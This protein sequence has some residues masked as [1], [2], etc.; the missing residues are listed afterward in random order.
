MSWYRWLSCT[1]LVAIVDGAWL[2]LLLGLFGFI[3]GIGHAQ[4][5]WLVATAVLVMGVLSCAL[6]ELV[7]QDWRV[8]AALTPC[9]GLLVS[10]LA[11][12]SASD[13]HAGTLGL[14]WPIE[15]LSGVV[16][17]STLATVALAAGTVA[18]LWWHGG[19]RALG[20]VGT[21]AI[22]RSFRT[23]L[24]VFLVLLA[25]EAA[26]D[27][28][29]GTHIAMGPFFI[30]SL[31]GMALARAPA[32]GVTLLAW[33][34]LIGAAIVAMVLSGLV[35]AL[36]AVAV[37]RG[38]FS[39]LSDVWLDFAQAVDR[40]VSATLVELLGTREV[41][42]L[43][44]QTTAWD[45]PQAFIL[46]VVVLGAMLFAPLFYRLLNAPPSLRL[47]GI[48]LDLGRA[49]HESIVDPG[50]D[51]AT[52][53]LETLLPRWRWRRRHGKVARVFPEHPRLAQTF[54][55]YYQ[56]LER[57]RAMGVEINLA[58]TPRER[59]A[60]LRAAFPEL[61]VD[62]LTAVFEAACY[63]L[64]AAPQTELD[65]LSEQCDGG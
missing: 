13:F 17:L 61:P 9:L 15:L 64:E 35:L 22:A 44:L 53:L 30:A 19:R 38:G 34:S 29:L 4:L 50:S 55:L 41:D 40:S 37:V 26:G 16:E 45:P 63:G 43:P 20:L 31:L 23:G 58:H 6:R 59:S 12:A 14:G 42:G 5:S 49:E 3:V 57:A 39:A 11:V 1:V 7:P 8:R 28:N 54:L 65:R 36:L 27:L 56:L 51:S 46:L 24:V 60:S 21:A 52:Q 32:H 47:P 10:W 25:F 2:Y 33:L 62:R 18:V 48:T